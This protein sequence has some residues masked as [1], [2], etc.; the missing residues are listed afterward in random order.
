MSAIFIGKRTDGSTFQ[1]LVQPDALTIHRS[2]AF[3]HADTNQDG[4][5]GL[6]ELTRLIELYNTRD[7]S[8]RTGKYHPKD[9]TEDGFAPRP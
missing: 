4:A 7:G 2:A 3:H 6:P 9:G 8:V 1:V 5:I